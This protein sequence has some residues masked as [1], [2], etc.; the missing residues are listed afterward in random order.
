[1]QNQSATN[2]RNLPIVSTQNSLSSS[3]GFNNTYL[4]Q[5]VRNNTGVFLNNVEIASSGTSI[6]NVNSP[7]I[8]NAPLYTGL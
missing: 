3:F 2:T 6:T 5:L 7:L 1:M 4:G 8:Q